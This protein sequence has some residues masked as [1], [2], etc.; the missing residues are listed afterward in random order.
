MLIC[1]YALHC[2][3]TLILFTSGRHY[4]IMET[5]VIIA[6]A[7]MVFAMMGNGNGNKKVNIDLSSIDD[8]P[9]ALQ[10]MAY[11]SEEPMD[12]GELT[13][14][15]QALNK[16]LAEEATTAPDDAQMLD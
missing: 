4:P 12:A 6:G 9:D 5:L 2:L 10:K 13:D 11:L 7:D 8:L 16:V 15:L 3:R 1:L 14:S